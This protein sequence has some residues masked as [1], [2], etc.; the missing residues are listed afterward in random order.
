M[1]NSPRSV[2]VAKLE[3]SS[4]ALT[5]AHSDATC[6]S[7]HR[8]PLEAQTALGRYCSDCHLSDDI[9]DGEFGP[10]CARCHSSESFRDVRRIR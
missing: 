3:L 9:H 1:P 4:F 2:A 5:G 6:E 10:D 7:C 8:R